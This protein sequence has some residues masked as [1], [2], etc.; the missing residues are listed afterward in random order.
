MYTDCTDVGLSGH[1]LIDGYWEMWVTEAMARVIKPGMVV[2][3]IG[4]NLGYY[5]LL[6]GELVGSTGWVHAFEPN[7][8]IAEHLRR[9]VGMNS[10]HRRTTVHQIALADRNGEAEMF[11]PVGQPKNA[12][13]M[14]GARADTIAVPLR[15]LD[16]FENLDRLDAIKID[17]EG[18][19]EAVWRGMEGILGGN[20]SLT[21]ILEFAA[22]RC[23]DPGRF[24]D[25]MLDRNFS[26]SLIGHDGR[27]VALDKTALLALPGNQDQML[28]LE[29]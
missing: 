15:R 22:D 2:A 4:A 17:V 11:V 25:D 5:T 9:N 23:V 24:I 21:I 1:L 27:I 8:P 18:A 13:I 20:R 3:D 26:L 29:R 7:P 28:L 16:S 6:M 14:T 10:A 12:T 19:E